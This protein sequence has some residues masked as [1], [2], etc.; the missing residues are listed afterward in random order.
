MIMSST[1]F[2]TLIAEFPF[3]SAAVSR[4]EH[5]VED[6]RAAQTREFT[7]A[8]MYHLIQPS[9]YRVLVQILTSAAEIGLLKKVVRVMSPSVKRAG[10]AD[11]DSILDIPPVLPDVRTGMDIEVMPDL[12]QLIYQIP[13]N[14]QASQA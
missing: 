8:R 3:E 1:K 6:D 12:I 11:F 2:D 10:I 4:L 5:L 14:Q 13:A 7:P 9:N